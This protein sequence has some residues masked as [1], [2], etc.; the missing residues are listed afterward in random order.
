M[1]LTCASL[2]CPPDLDYDETAELDEEAAAASTPPPSPTPSSSSAEAAAA[3]AVDGAA[4]SDGGDAD[5][6][7]CI[8]WSCCA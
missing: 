1:W 2:A 6:G 3:A 5:T 4:M 7:A 8:E